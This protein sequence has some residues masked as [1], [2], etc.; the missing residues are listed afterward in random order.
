MANF[1]IASAGAQ[2]SAAEV[3]RLVGKTCPLSEYA[4]Q[5]VLAIIPDA[6]R[7][8]PVGMVFKAFYD[9][10]AGAVRQLDIMVALGTHQPM[11]EQA[12]CKRIEITQEERETT[13]RA[14]RFF[15]HEWDN[16]DA[17][18]EIGMILKAQ[19]N[20]LTGGRFA[21]DIPVEIN[22]KL[23]EYDRIVILGP[24]F[25]HEVVGFSGGNKYLFPGV[26]GPKLLNFFHWLAAVILNPKIIGHKWT[27]VRK[28]IDYA[29]GLVDLP[30]QCFCMVVQDGGLG[31]IFEG[32]PETA[33]DEAADLSR[34]LHVTYKEKPF[35]TVLSCAPPMYNE[36]WV[37]GKC[38]YKLEPV[39]ADDG[40][41]IIYAPHIKEVSV[42]HGQK[43]YSVGYHC[44]DYFLNQWER[45]KE[46]PWG[47]LA[48]STHVYGQ[49]TFIDGIEKPR[50]RVTLATGLSSEQCRRLNLGYRDP[51][52]VDVA[53]FANREDEGVLLVPKAGEELFQLKN[54]PAWARP[55]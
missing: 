54:P 8:A 31:G 23:Y 32:T 34:D 55:D 24:V 19:L 40:E 37:G 52:T 18:R 20:E 10:V 53:A 9:Q 26:S 16:P 11:S 5:R 22:R 25:P 46:E 12:I 36:L 42:T 47:V 49:G 29:G 21:M 27:V 38:M 17:L 1:I 45:F 43:I 50:A 44:R 39:L 6:T 41:L 7:S 35:R 33:W 30:K 14:V 15:N 2:V 48:H 28:V 3:A 13:Y 51:K 4:G